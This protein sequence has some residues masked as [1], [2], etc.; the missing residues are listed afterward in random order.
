MHTFDPLPSYLVNR[1][2]G[3]K[4]TSYSENKSWYRRLA[5]EGQR[6]RAMV[7][8]CC[9]SRVQ[10]EP[11]FGVDAGEI[12]VHRSIA[13]LVPPYQAEGDYRGTSAAIE[14]AVT[15][16]C[17]SHLIVL[18]HSDCGGVKGCFE[19]CEG[20]APE[21][22]KPESFVGRWMNIL[23]PGYDRIADTADD[24][25]RAAALEK[26]AVVVS[27]ENIMT[28]PFVENAVEA[29]K[30]TLHG[31]WQDIGE[32]TLKQYLGKDQGFQPV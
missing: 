18:G 11:I 7:V 5:Q 24:S 29:E 13:N 16:L 12:F 22:E 23:R 17:V 14:Y 4:A 31:L 21:L 26:E 1:Y 10:V 27:L 19:M 15:A 6:P 32:G 28:F 20:R 2:N 25:E 30:L 3:W 8:A 9:D